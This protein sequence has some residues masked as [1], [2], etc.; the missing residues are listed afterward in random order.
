MARYHCAIPSGHIL[1][2]ALAMALELPCKDSKHTVRQTTAVLH[3]V[4]Q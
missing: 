1:S 3:D 2:E 4:Q